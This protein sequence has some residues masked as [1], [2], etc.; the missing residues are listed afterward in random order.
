MNTS[1]AFGDAAGERCH[2]F[3]KHIPGDYAKIIYLLILFILGATINTFAYSVLSK[4][5]LVSNVTD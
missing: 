2:P 1:S 5:N 4:Q 3:P